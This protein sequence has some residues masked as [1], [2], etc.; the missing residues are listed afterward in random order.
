MIKIKFLVWG[1]DM[2]KRRL[3]ENKVC[4]LKK[5]PEG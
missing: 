2:G 3:E 5:E 4:S 1:G